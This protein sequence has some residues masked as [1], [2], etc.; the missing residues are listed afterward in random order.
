V[1]LL[2]YLIIASIG[3]FLGNTEKNK[4]GTVL[5][6]VFLGWAAIVF[7]NLFNSGIFLGFLWAYLGVAVSLLAE[8]DAGENIARK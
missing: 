4:N 8:K 5:V 2:V 1:I 7:P 6:F 3:A